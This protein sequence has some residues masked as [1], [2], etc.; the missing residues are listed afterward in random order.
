MSYTKKKV[1]IPDD[2]PIFH[3]N[4]QNILMEFNKIVQAVA[5]G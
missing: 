4:L 2:Q 3:M 1:E 5:A